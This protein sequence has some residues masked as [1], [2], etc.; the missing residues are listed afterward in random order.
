VILVFT[1]FLGGGGDWGGG[2]RGGMGTG[3]PIGL[4]VINT[5]HYGMFINLYC[6]F[7]HLREFYYHQTI[8]NT[9]NTM[10]HNYKNL[11]TSY[12]N[13]SHVTGVKCKFIRNLQIEQNY[14]QISIT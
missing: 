14:A 8:Q 9:F 7:L 12:S 11:Q 6:L 13:T 10:Q 3:F 4:L 2:D 5:T 1:A